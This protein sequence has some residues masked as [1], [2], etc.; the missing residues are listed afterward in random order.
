MDGPTIV[1]AISVVVA[2]AASITAPIIAGRNQR[3][4]DAAKFEHERGMKD[5]DELRAL[6]D[7]IAVAIPATIQKQGTLRSKHNTSGSTDMNDYMDQVSAFTEAR[8]ELIHMDTRLLLRLGHA[9]PVRQALVQAIQTIHE[10]GMDVIA[11]VTV[12][13][14][15][16][17]DW[18]ERSFG[19]RK[20]MH[21]AQQRFLEAASAFVSAPMRSLILGEP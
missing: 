7:E 12:D 17:D 20:A 16:P 1:A 8:E 11:L 4:S 14:P 9:H 21:A 6:I 13:R 3:G 19:E 15:R 10:A 18:Q 5:T 2:G